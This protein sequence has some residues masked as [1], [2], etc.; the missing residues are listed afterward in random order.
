MNYDRI[1]LELMDRVSALEDE[2]ENLKNSKSKIVV[3]EREGE[4]ESIFEPS[5]DSNSRDTTKYILDGKRY[6][7]SRLVLAIVKKYMIQHPNISSEELMS[8]FD[9]SLQGSLGVVRQ[10]DEVKKAYS[11]CEKRFFINTN[12]VIN[13]S[14]GVCVVCNQWGIGNIVNMLKRAEQLG[15]NVDII[16]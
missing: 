15:I 16:K 6:G 12:E 7:K 14:D 2:V 9:R 3:V 13:T 11:D 4:A 10:L 5:T 8:V 1:I